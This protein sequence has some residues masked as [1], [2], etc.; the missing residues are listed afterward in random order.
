[1]IIFHVYN[2][3]GKDQCRTPDS[4]ESARAVA[5]RSP[6][7]PQIHHTSLAPLRSSRNGSSSP[8]INGNTGW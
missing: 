3:K 6:I 2:F 4:P 7:S 8:V 1:M 5:P